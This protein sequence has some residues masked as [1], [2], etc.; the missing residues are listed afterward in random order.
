[1]DV[2][3]DGNEQTGAPVTGYYTEEKYKLQ[4]REGI[5]RL[6]WVQLRQLHGTTFVVHN[7]E[8]ERS[9]LPTLR[10]RAASE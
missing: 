3:H 2:A 4:G 8:Q 5:R 9:D 7:V 10:H 6:R 1:M